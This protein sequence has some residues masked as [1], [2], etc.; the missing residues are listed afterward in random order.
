MVSPAPSVL[1]VNTRSYLP[2]RHGR[3]ICQ[4]VSLTSYF[5][6]LFYRE[7]EGIFGS[8]LPAKCDVLSV[9]IMSEQ[10][11]KHSIFLASLKKSCYIHIDRRKCIMGRK[12]CHASFEKVTAVNKCRRKWKVEWNSANFL[13]RLVMF[14]LNVPYNDD[15]VK[16]HTALC[17]WW[18]TFK[19]TILQLRPRTKTLSNFSEYPRTSPKISEL[20]RTSPGNFRYWWFVKWVFWPRACPDLWRSLSLWL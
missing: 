7:N 11:P 5:W 10:M 16:T 9:V 13:L 15:K 17:R 14:Y 8:L 18:K 6:S 1:F 20:N 19:N 2:T 4:V 3:S 12:W